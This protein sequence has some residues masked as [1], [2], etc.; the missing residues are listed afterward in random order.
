MVWNLPISG[1]SERMCLRSTRRAVLVS[2]FRPWQIALRTIAPSAFERFFSLVAVLTGAL[3]FLVTLR[4]E[5]VLTVVLLVAVCMVILRLVGLLS[6]G[7]SY[8]YREYSLPLIRG[9]LVPF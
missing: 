7:S 3:D 5:E 8:L 9:P 4:A 2:S 1:R 6:S